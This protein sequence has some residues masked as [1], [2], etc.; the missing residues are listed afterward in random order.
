MVKKQKPPKEPIDI[1]KL[2]KTR[3]EEEKR[4]REEKNQ[5]QE[6]DDTYRKSQVFA[7]PSMEERETFA[8]DL[9]KKYADKKF[10]DE[11][12]LL[13]LFSGNCL[14]YLKRTSK[15]CEKKKYQK[16]P[17]LNEYLFLTTLNHKLHIAAVEFEKKFGQHDKEAL[18]MIIKNADKIKTIESELVALRDKKEGEKSVYAMHRDVIDEGK[19]FIKDNIGLFSFKC[20]E[21]QTVM[22]IDGLPHWALYKGELQ[23]SPYY[24]T[25]SKELWLL[26]QKGVIPIHLMA[27]VLHTSIEGLKFTCQARGEDWLKLSEAELVAEEKK[28]KVLWDEITEMEQEK[29]KGRIKKLGLE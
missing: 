9:N 4:A 22:Q 1:Q 17:L 24:F 10:A 23:G 2:I 28:F 5:K 6:K 21:C 27:F 15:D 7:D 20:N 12:Y 18:D 8:V 19:K 11:N 29:Q 26:V 14:E 16:S 25:W 13:S 3:E